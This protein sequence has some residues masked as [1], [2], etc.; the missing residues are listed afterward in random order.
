MH[1]IPRRIQSGKAIINKLSWQRFLGANEGR[2]F[3][4][5]ARSR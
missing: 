3:D 1:S 5:V 4:V 2:W